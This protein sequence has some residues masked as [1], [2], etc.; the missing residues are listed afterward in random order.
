MKNGTLAAVILGSVLAVGIIGG[1]NMIG[2]GL[3]AAR[4]S[5]RVVTVKG[6]AE[7]EVPAN[8]AMWP[9]VFSTTDNDLARTAILSP[10][11]S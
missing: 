11:R 10:P 5:E 2:E 6:L 1:G 8:L 9:I 3:F 7:R 4:A